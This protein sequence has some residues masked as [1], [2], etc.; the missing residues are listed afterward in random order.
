[1]RTLFILYIPVATLIAL[2]LARVMLRQRRSARETQ[3]MSGCPRKAPAVDTTG[4]APGTAKGR[5]VV[6]AAD[7]KGSPATV[8]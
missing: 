4:L 5:L 8:A 6:V 7:A 3:K 1:M 2:L